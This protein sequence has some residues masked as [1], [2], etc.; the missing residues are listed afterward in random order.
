MALANNE[1][2]E[3]NE[4]AWCDG[5]AIQLR[6][7]AL[8]IQRLRS[9]CGSGVGSLATASCPCGG[10]SSTA[11]VRASMADVGVDWPRQRRRPVEARTFSTPL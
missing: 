6:E 5:L 8:A 9:A 4:L 3:L 11:G 2:D 7:S 10:I 1:Q